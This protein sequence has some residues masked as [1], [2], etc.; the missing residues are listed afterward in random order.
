MLSVSQVSGRAALVAVLFALVGCAGSA[1]RPRP[2]WSKAS[3]PD[4]PAYP[5]GRFITAVGSST[6][7]VEE[8]LGRARAN[9]VQQ[10]SS[11]I[12]V[13]VEHWASETN[14]TEAS[15]Y[16]E[17]IRASSTFTH[18]ELIRVVEQAKAEES[19]YALAVL[20]R[21]E[22]EAALARD[23]ASDE[24]HFQAAAR[25]ALEAR[26]GRRSGESAAAADE[27]LATLPAVESS[28]LVRRAV[29]RAVSPS[30]AAHNSLR[31]SLIALQVAMKTRRVVDIR[32]GSGT[33]PALLQRAV[34]AVK[35][36]GLRVAEGK[37]C[38]AQTSDAQLDAT[39][40]VLTPEETCG[41]GSFGPK[42]EVS[43][44]LYARGCSGGAEGEGR[45][46]QLKGAHT[47]DPERAKAKAWEKVTDQV[48][49]SAVRDALKGTITAGARQ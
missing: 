19:F 12:Q 45:I 35:R 18:A 41:D 25:R 33:Y 44:R 47:T 31:T 49:E 34:A 22:A 46:S 7:S 26:E 9:A 16:L 4:V 15:K 10:V 14:G 40:L 17:K 8:A 6:V 32:L 5:R 27:A 38:D 30:E 13:E 37:G 28:Y 23:G 11:Q 29:L 36:L 21:A 43:I 1:P 42:C 39:E 20:D 24:A 3:E 2:A 48:V